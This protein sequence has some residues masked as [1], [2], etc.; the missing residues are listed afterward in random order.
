MVDDRLLKKI[1]GLFKLG[2]SGSNSNEA[3]MMSAITKAR[4][5]MAR[6]AIS[7][8]Q[9][10]AA[11]DASTASRQGPRIVVN[12][13]TAYTRK[14][15]NLARYDEII[16][17]AVGYLTQTQ[18]LIYRNRDSQRNTY[19]TLKFVGE[20][21]DIQIA[22]ALFI[23]FLQTTRREASAAMGRGKNM[24]GKKHT[25]YAMGF[26]ARVCERA[27]AK[28][29]VFTAQETTALVRIEQ[30]KFSAITLWMAEQ[31]GMKESKRRE[32]ALDGAAFAKGYIAGEKLDLGTKGLK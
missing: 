10:Q 27:R 6:H 18:P 13:Y 30:D 21:T 15:S 32:P 26:A 14:I 17:A 11:M 7:E 16:A 20:Q 25:S 1:V 19:T 12:I 8:G 28:V 31:T 22:S 3:E 29:A 9:V 23:I 5:L 24:W 2:A 4:E